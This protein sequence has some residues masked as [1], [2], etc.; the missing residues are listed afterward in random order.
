MNP[1]KFFTFQLPGKIL[2]GRKDKLAFTK[3]AEEISQ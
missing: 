2:T 1:V 3:T